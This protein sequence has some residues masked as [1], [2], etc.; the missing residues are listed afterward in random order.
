MVADTVYEACL[1]VLQDE[2]LEDDDRTDKLEELLR[3]ETGLTGKSLENIVL[4]CL[5]RFREAGSSSTSPPPS[6]HTVIRRASPAPWQANRVPTPVNHSP[7]TIQPPPGFGVAP[8]AF[9]RA[10]SSTASPFTSPRPSPRLAFSTPHIPHSPSLSAYQ[11]SEHSTTPDIYGDLGSDSV[12]WLV[13][14]DSGSTESSSFMDDN[15][16]NGGAPE[17]IQPSMD[18]SPYDMLRSVLRDDRPD[19]EIEKALEAN[20]Y[21]LSAALLTLMGNQ[22]FDNQSM[23]TSLDAAN[24]Y[25]VGKSMSPAFRPATPA[26][27]AKSNIVCKY[28]LTTGH[29]ARADC[30]FSHDTSTTLCK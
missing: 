28:Y 12:D 15:M 6:R 25:V 20:G 5:W 27:Q 21:D 30:R 18:M 9:T 2:S 7:R 13:N 26:G 1:P 16:L 29:C 8:P 10:K 11:F 3:K 23:Q 14:D 24:T 17:F 19:E 4:D 22:A